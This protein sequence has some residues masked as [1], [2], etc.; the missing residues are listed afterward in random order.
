MQIL[1]LMIQ[2]ILAK[3]VRLSKLGIDVEAIISDGIVSDAA[4]EA[5]NI[6]FNQ[7]VKFS[8]RELDI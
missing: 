6:K 1:Y 7:D 3:Q 4:A 5:N 2:K 8:Q